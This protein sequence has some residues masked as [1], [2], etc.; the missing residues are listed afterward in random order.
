M[1]DL[2]AL[3]AQIRLAHFFLR[4]DGLKTHGEF[5][6]GKAGDHAFSSLAAVHKEVLIALEGANTRLEKDDIRFRLSLRARAARLVS[7]P[8]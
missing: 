2:E 7:S 1:R 8:K 5:F 4:L 6:G 3:E